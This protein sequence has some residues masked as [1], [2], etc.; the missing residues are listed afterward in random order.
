ME[1][2]ELSEYEIEIRKTPDGIEIYIPPEI[3][4]QVSEE[5]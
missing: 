4:N 1:H 2:Q 3:V 5:Q